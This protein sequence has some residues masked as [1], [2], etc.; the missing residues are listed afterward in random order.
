VLGT[1]FL[2]E[3]SAASTEEL[4][5]IFG[6]RLRKKKVPLKKDTSGLANS[7]SLFLVAPTYYGTRYNYILRSA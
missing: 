2:V 1:D 3:L 4:F 5:N 7:V 6:T